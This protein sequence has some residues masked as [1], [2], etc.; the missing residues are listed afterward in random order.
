M[1]DEQKSAG[2][3]DDRRSELND[4]LNVGSP[5]YQRTMSFAD[6]DSDR[7]LLMHKVW[8][9]T[10]WMVDT[11]TGSISNAGRYMDIMDWCREKFGDEAW[12]IHGKVGNWHCGGVTV[13]G[14]TWLG[15]A[16]QEMLASF[17]EMWVDV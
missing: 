15:F 3:S 4:L 6:E 11:Y 17:C 5:L 14:W 7:G 2:R 13:H 9:G 16:T 8:D 1:T 12:P 10:P